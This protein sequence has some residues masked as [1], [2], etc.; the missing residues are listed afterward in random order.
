MQALAAAA[1][2]VFAVIGWTRSPTGSPTDSPAQ[3]DPAVQLPA[4]SAGRVT[5]HADPPWAGAAEWRSRGRLE[6]VT[7]TGAASQLSSHAYVYLPPQYFQ[8]RYANT[9]FPAVEVLTGY[10]GRDADLIQ[11]IPFPQSLLALIDAGRAQPVV[12]VMTRPAVTYPRDTE[13]TDVP[14]GPQVQT[15][16]GTD[17]PAAVAHAYRV[18][19]TAW[20]AAGISTGAYCAVKLAMMHPDLFGAA[21]SMSGYGLA[22]R[23]RTTGD[24]W[25]G[26]HVL[27]N[28]NDLEWRLRHLPA[29]P[30]SVL[31]TMGS[32]EHGFDE[33]P[34]F[35]RFLGLVKP[36]M[37]ITSIVFAG[38]GHSK[39]SFA[40]ELPQV[41]TWLCGQIPS[42]P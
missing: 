6:S 18:R 2:A 40:A 7:I 36:P 8:A 29:P 26:S 13:C 25:G 42:P 11:G 41:L 28:L 24:L 39:A 15:F 22:L 5:L 1:L 14:S 19:P 4:G 17:L 37:R 20:G 33:L 35:H 27:R 10:P 38:R 3:A 9:R 30:I 34:D 16:F 12:L 21:A 31:A 32:A 23:D